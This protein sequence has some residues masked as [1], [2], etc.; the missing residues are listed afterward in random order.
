MNTYHVPQLCNELS[1]GREG[2]ATPIEGHWH[3]GTIK[4][5]A[6]GDMYVL[7]VPVPSV[8]QDINVGRQGIFVSGT[9]EYND[10]FPKTPPNKWEFCNYSFYN[11]T[12][13]TL[14]FNACD[15]GEYIPKLKTVIQY[16]NHEE[17]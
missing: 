17:N 1:S 16:P 14:S 10:G 6:A 7:H 4:G 13:N 12:S 3:S 15:P 8:T 2:F 5:I 9:I 11:N